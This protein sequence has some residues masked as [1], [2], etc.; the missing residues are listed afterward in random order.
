VRKWEEGKEKSG[1]RS[2][3]EGIKGGVGN[4][5]KREKEGIEG[6]RKCESE[7]KK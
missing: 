7:R 4:R 6:E 2:R 5:G 3:E 1:L